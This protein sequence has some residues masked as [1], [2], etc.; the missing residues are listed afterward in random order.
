MAEP[1][2]LVGGAPCLDF[3]NTV[4]RMVHKPWVE[5][6]NGYADLCAWS[7]QTGSLPRAQAR[8]LAGRADGRAAEA[9]LARAREV[10]EACYRLF[11]ALAEDRTPAPADLAVLND[12]LGL[13]LAHLRVQGAD[14]GFAFGWERA[15]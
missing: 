11:L 4:D 7:E 12:E 13:A 5:N 3:V 6:L 2:Q 8:A 10:R 15:A 14:S 1:F 9:V